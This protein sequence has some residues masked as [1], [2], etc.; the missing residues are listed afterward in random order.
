MNKNF[1]SLILLKTADW[2]PHSFLGTFIISYIMRLSENAIIPTAL[3]NIFFY[4]FIFISSALCFVC[5]KQTKMMSA[6][7]A[8]IF[9][10]MIL[11]A[12]IAL[13]KEQ[14][15]NYIW[16]LGGIYGI[17]TGLTT[18]SL[19][20]AQ[21]KLIKDQIKFSAYRLMFSGVAKIGFPV[22]CGF[23][24]GQISFPSMAGFMLLCCGSIYTLSFL[25]KNQSSSKEVCD[26]LDFSGFIKKKN[27]SRYKK[28]IN[29]LFVAEFFAGATGPINIVQTMLIVYLF[30]TDLN[31]GIINSGLLIFI[32]IFRFF[33]G[34]FG[35]QKQFGKIFWAIFVFLAVAICALFFIS[36][37][38]FLVYAFFTSL[39]FSLVNMLYEPIMYTL[40]QNTE[41]YEKEFLVM[42][43]FALNVGRVF[44][45]FLFMGINLFADT[46]FALKWFLIGLMIIYSLQTIIA[47]N[48]NKTLKIRE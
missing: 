35:G 27:Q 40:F 19:N 10:L 43:E 25:I 4:V 24:L 1:Y 46:Q 42:R 30:K 38:N 29:K 36:E 5:F 21:A 12:I 45:L 14:S 37:F 15:L 28:E 48:I 41:H 6:Y 18:I 34:K 7:R 2:I 13:F 9:C 20:Y 23:L 39:G 26:K 3:Y 44:I 11:L 22:L 8:G 17:A 31:L 32:T 47:H 33:F 16:I